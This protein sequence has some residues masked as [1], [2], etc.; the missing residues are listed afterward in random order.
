MTRSVDVGV[1]AV[2][3][4]CGASVRAGDK[5]PAPS[6]VVHRQIEFELEKKKDAVRAA[7]GV[8]APA[9]PLVSLR[10]SSSSFFFAVSQS[11]REGGAAEREEEEGRGTNNIQ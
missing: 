9:K 1:C 11:E 5:R 2:G 10:S 7:G 3:A 4:W 8:R 6:T